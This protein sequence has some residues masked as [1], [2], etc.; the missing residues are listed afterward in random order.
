MTRSLLQLATPDKS[1]EHVKWTVTSARYQPLALG[2]RA[3]APTILGRV[4]SILSIPGS[5]AVLPAL[6]TTVP[7]TGAGVRAPV[8]LGGS[9]STW[10]LTDLVPVCPS[11]LSRG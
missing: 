5:V 10:T 9:L 8:M 7:I 6:L 1:P 3:R 11:Q 4:L 2:S